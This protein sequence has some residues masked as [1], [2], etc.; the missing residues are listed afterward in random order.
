[1]GLLSPKANTKAKA[2]GAKMVRMNQ[3]EVEAIRAVNA[4]AQ[5]VLAEHYRKYRTPCYV[6]VYQD[7]DTGLLFLGFPWLSRYESDEKANNLQ[8][9][10]RIRI[11]F[12]EQELPD[13]FRTIRALSYWPWR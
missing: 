5:N 3:T 10:Y 4:R 7:P 1:M 13:S 6:N 11:K 8:R 12:K 9:V 2:E